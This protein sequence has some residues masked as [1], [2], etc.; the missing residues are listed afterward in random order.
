MSK[1]KL[2][3][4][5]S[6]SIQ[7][8]FELSLDID[9]HTQSASQT[10]EKAIAGVTSGKIGSGETG[11][12]KGKH[13]GFWL[14]HTSIISQYTAPSFFVDEMVEG[15]FKRFRHEHRFRE[16]GNQ[17]TMLDQLTY[18]VPY[19]VIGQLFNFFFLKKYLRKFI[20]N[21]NLH[22]KKALENRLV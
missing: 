19:G 18:E 5:I 14:S 13:F 16:S 15:H 7:A 20:V 3:T 2:E 6:A 9:F 8:V 12:W 11:T 17:T 21:R 22:L 10:Q 1:I 4:T